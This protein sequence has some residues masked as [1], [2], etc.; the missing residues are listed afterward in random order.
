MDGN[1]IVA[2][3]EAV[4]GYTRMMLEAARKSEWG[5]LPVLEEKRF[6]FVEILMASDKGDFSDAKL[7]ARKSELI[8]EILAVDAETKELTEAWM[9]E[10]RQ[11]LDSIGSEKKLNNAYAGHG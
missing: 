3:Y 4:W 5:D 7:N 6:S 2:T 1:E 11:I 10:L 9:V 8:Q